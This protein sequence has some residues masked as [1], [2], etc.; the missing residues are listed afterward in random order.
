MVFAETLLDPAYPPPKSGNPDIFLRSHPP[1]WSTT[2]TAPS[3]TRWLASDR[4]PPP[5]RSF[6]PWIF[7]FADSAADALPGAPACM[8]VMENSRAY[9]T[10]MHWS[11]CLSPVREPGQDRRG[12]L[13]G[14][15]PGQ[16]VSGGA[17]TD[18]GRTVDGTQSAVCPRPADCAVLDMHTFLARSDPEAGSHPRVLR[19]LYSLAG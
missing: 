7:D 2:W 12:H 16:E 1:R 17:S 4:G 18:Q 6:P 15:V 10:P 11:L 9:L 3:R 13:W 8:R 19:R 14:R 5:P